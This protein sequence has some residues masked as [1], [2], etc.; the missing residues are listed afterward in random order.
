MKTIL[1]VIIILLLTVI[2]VL[3][4]FISDSLIV[5]LL[6]ITLSFTRFESLLDH[7][8]NFKGEVL[9]VENEKNIDFDQKEHKK[10][11]YDSYYIK[12]DVRYDFC[13]ECGKLEDT[14]DKIHRL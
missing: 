13:G 2:L 8:N 6:W 11:I 3:M 14:G 9:S 4:F 7:K 1:N 10:C 12:N 5:I